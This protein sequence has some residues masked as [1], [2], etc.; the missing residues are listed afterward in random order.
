MSRNCH[1]T[2]RQEKATRKHTAWEL[3]V[4]CLPKQRLCRKNNR[5]IAIITAPQS[6]PQSTSVNGG[7]NSRV[8]AFPVTALTVQTI[9]KDL[10]GD[11]KC[12]Q[13][14]LTDWQLSGNKQYTCNRVSTLLNTDLGQVWFTRANDV[15]KCYSN[16]LW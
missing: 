7:G 16:I 4:I 8:H 14:G 12:L 2:D 13:N 15:S 5:F 10:R 11:T 9:M 6:K 1:K 3:G